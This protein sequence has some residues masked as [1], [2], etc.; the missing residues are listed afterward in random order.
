[1]IRSLTVV[2]QP[3]VISFDLVSRYNSC[4]GRNPSYSEINDMP[5]NLDYYSPEELFDAQL[6]RIYVLNL[7]SLLHKSV[8]FEFYIEM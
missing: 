8:Q 5:R 7:E 3:L 2:S 1:M 4:H 6:D